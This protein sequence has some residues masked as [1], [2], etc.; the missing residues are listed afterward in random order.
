MVVHIGGKKYKAYVDGAACA[1][2]TKDTIS[3]ITG[4]MLLSS[5]GYVLKD[6]NGLTLTAKEAE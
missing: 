6:V 1:F 3:D 2:M 4:I 5:E